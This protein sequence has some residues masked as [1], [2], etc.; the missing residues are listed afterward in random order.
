M[1]LLAR[2]SGGG[3]GAHILDSRKDGGVMPFNL[4]WIP[5]SLFAFTIGVVSSS[6]FGYGWLP[7]AVIFAYL[8]MQSGHGTFYNMRGWESA[9]P[10]RKQSIE[11]VVRPIFN[12]FGWS[13]YKPAYSWA[14]MGLKGMAIGL[15][16]FPFGLLLAFLWPASYAIK[17]PVWGEYLSGAFTGLCLVLYLFL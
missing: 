10:D 8:A 9:N 15:V 16:L 11:Y 13:I 14:C 12:M 5:E 6:H 17:G 2:A 3:V 4:T 7:F 1:A